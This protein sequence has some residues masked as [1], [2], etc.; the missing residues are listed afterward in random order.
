MNLD[1][2]TERDLRDSLTKLSNF[3]D[4]D[5][6]VQR[7]HMPGTVFTGSVMSGLEPEFTYPRT[8]SKTNFQRIMWPI[9]IV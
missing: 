1:I 2:R 6:E 3:T 9:R 7:D 8:W 5:T 4:E